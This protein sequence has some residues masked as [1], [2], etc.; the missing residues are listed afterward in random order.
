MTVALVPPD[1]LL[2]AEDVADRMHCSV[3]TI[4]E[5]TRTKAIPHFK[6]PVPR[7]VYYPLGWLVAWEHGADLE[8][9]ELSDGG[10]L[11]RPRGTKKKAT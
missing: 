8:V 2:R 1:Q 6:R 11:V 5:L 9:V 3:R 4:H 7:R 10:R